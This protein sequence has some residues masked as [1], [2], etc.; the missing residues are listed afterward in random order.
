MYT[1][2]TDRFRA[3]KA[4]IRMIER[5]TPAIKPYN[6]RLYGQIYGCELFTKVPHLSRAIPCT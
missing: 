2:H 5:I 6:S 1:G 4:L 3:P